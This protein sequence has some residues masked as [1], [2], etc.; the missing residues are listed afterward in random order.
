LFGEVWYADGTV[1]YAADLLHAAAFAGGYV[2]GAFVG[3]DLVGA[4]LGILGRHDGQLVLHSHVTGIRP[5]VEHRG[6][7]LT[8]KRHQRAWASDAGLEAIIWTFDP[9]VRRNAWFN[10][11]KLGA[12]IIDY[13]ESFYGETDDAINAGDETD[14]AVVRW[15]THATVT[16]AT[17]TGFVVV[18]AHATVAP[19]PPDATVINVATPPD[20]VALR[21][22]D[23]TTARRWRHA[24][25]H[26]FL[27]AFASGF[28][29]TGITRNGL[30]TLERR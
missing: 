10:L 19:R 26:A 24:T 25:R 18:D 13:V 3:S 14:R 23:A 17:R 6:I 21:N 15:S 22:D 27:D 16:N 29:V 20:I 28:S 30:Y 4:S 2:A 8:L 1:P 7:G 9:L 11:A 12:R 5:G